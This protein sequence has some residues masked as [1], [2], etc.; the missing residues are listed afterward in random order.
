MGIYQGYTGANW[1]SYQKTK[2]EELEQQNKVVFY[3][4]PRINK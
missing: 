3:Y 2:L 1:K 4:N